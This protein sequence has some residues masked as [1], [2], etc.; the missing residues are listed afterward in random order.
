MLKLDDVL[1]KVIKILD[2]F[3]NILYT[4]CAVDR[5]R[6]LQYTM[7]IL[8]K[9][10]GE[11][12]VLSKVD[13]EFEIYGIDSKVINDTIR[14]IQ[15][16]CGDKL[17]EILPLSADY[18]LSKFANG[19]WGETL[20]PR[21]LTDLV[22]TLMREKECKSVYNP[23]AGFGSYAFGDFIE[24]YYGQEINFATCNMA[25]MRLELN[26]IDY[27]NFE[28]CDSIKNWDEH[29]A[30]CIVSTPP[31]GLRNDEELKKIYHAST[32][33]EFLL[34]KFI[35]GHAKYGFFVVT[36]GVC[37]K[38]QGT[39]LD[40]RKDICDKHLLEM[41]INLPSGIFS[42]TGVSTSLIILNRCRNKEDKVT[43]FDA[44][45]FFN[46][47]KNQQDSLDI[48]WI[49]V[50]IEDESLSTT[51]KV[52][53][54]DIYDNDCSFDLSRYAVQNL[55]VDEGQKI[56][57]LGDILTPAEG[58]RCDFTG[59]FVNNV[60]ESSNFA[61]TFKHLSNDVDN[62]V[63]V[64]KTKYK[65]HGPHIVI[66]MQGKIYIHRGET[67][68][69]IGSALRRLV[70]KVDDSIVDIEYLALTLLLN[71]QLQRSYF[72][73]G[74]ARVNSSQFL[75]YK[76]VIDSFSHQRQMVKNI[77]RKYLKSEQKRL[78]IREAGGDLTH[79]L[80]MPKDKIG[81][82]ID[83]LLSSESISN[84][85]KMM[86]KAIEDNFRY[87]LR[88]IN[89]VGVDF[90][91]VKGSSH[92]IH[93]A[94]MLK[95]YVNSLKNLKFA[96][97]YKIE[98]EMGISEDVTINCD[99]DLIRVILD[100][101]FRNAY[102]HGFE[103][104]YSENN[105]VMLGCKMVDYEGKLYTCITIANNGKPMDPEFRTEDYATMGKKAGKMG[106]TGKG[107]YHIYAIAKKYD[108]YIRVSSSKK[109]SFILDVLIPAE[110]WNSNENI[111]EYGSKCL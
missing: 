61:S 32:I 36:R 55:V 24:K 68:F 89:T 4:R 78:G 41:V 73:A 79:M 72:G 81:N 5:Y 108:G 23:F 101:A 94:E 91:D 107:G 31:F 47:R 103:Q 86:V 109:W 37:F 95:E 60:I 40:L 9:A 34:R 8:C 111:E 1:K 84:D 104:K 99:I 52:S 10:K 42:S 46:K 14:D 16:V 87:M 45:P 49:P 66:N 64:D 54:R 80:G 71:E 29:D 26:N 67:D 39:A 93:I 75:K 17:L 96:N 51:F 11:C 43:F 62:Y 22:L 56:V 85:D 20:Q 28:C 97:N 3:V 63:F 76:I 15:E 110:N 33:E 88:L 74:I 25:K 106:N 35:S 65:F 12:R 2:A 102:S 18:I 27:S 6:I 13:S 105:K 30:D 57:A 7:A 58:E 21:E 83:L 69:Y 48:S 70:F 90:E 82:L 53:Y 19:S 98:I 38:S 44:E 59:E 100:S 50:A 92:E 77:K